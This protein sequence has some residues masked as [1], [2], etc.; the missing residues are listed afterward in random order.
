[1]GQ[2]M[3]HAI[4]VAQDCLIWHQWEGICLVLWRLDTLEKDSARGEKVWV[5]EGASS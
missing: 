3:A 5:D 4:Y 1:M 2:S